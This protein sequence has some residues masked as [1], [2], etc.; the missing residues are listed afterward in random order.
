MYRPAALCLSSATEIA[1]T[2]L[3]SD[4]TGNNDEYRSTE[5][6]IF[7]ILSQAE[8]LWSLHENDA[9]VCGIEW[10]LNGQKAG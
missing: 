1:T 3:R 2:R 10:D 5:A 4:N 7:R 6:R 8:Q 9:P